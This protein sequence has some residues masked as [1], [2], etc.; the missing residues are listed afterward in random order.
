MPVRI[1]SDTNW[2]KVWAGNRAAVA[3]QA[4]GSLWCWGD[5]P[6]PD[7]HTQAAT[8]SAPMRNSPDT[9]WVDAGLVGDTAFAIKS[10]G[11]LWAWGSQAH[12]YTEASDPAQDAVPTRVGTNSDWKAISTCTR[13]WWCPG[14]TK[15]D[16]SLWLMD[17][18]DPNP[19]GPK[20]PYPPVRFRRAAFKRESV[21]YAGGALHFVAPGAH[22]G[23]GV[24]LTANGEVWTW[25]VVLGEPPSFHDRALNLAVKLVNYL[26]IRKRIPPPYP[27][28]YP[29]SVFRE[30]PWQ[31]RN[32]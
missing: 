17:A 9:N 13:G 5:I 22:L 15:K 19:N 7:V 8:I 26:P 31:L 10:D 6:N 18:T 28:P 25:G 21:A 24:A 29:A 4:D 20:S 27:D 1:G 14:L 2:I 3:M 23:I 12:I 30:E 32:E 11:T 16:G